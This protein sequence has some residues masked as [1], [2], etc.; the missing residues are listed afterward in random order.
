[1]TV[2]SWPCFQKTIITNNILWMTLSAFTHVNFNRKPSREAHWSDRCLGASFKFAIHLSFVLYYASSTGFCTA[3]W[4]M[5]C[6]SFVFMR[7]CCIQLQSYSD[8][9]CKT[10]PR[11]QMLVQFSFKRD[12]RLKR[13]LITK[14]TYFLNFC[15]Y[16]LVCISKIFIFDSLVW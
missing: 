15:S 1:M 6:K 4:V 9:V 13:N 7:Y 14:T 11:A 3:V 10:S 8:I 16:F 5:L 2:W 12:L